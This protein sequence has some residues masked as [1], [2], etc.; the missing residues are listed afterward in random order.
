MKRGTTVLVLV[1][2]L[3]GCMHTRRIEGL[4]GA[5]P[6]AG[7]Q[8]GQAQLDAINAVA[9]GRRGRIE[10]MD[11]HVLA[12][13]Q[14]HAERAWVSWSD[15]GHEAQTLPWSRVARITFRRPVRGALR[16][17]GVGFAAGMATTLGLAASVDKNTPYEDIPPAAGAV[18]IGLLATAATS[19][20]GTVVGG[21]TDR[22]VFVIQQPVR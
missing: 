22:Q 16:G 14:I 10:T 18:I 17:L 21:A 3:S 8:L 13:R 9:L 4:R 2:M 6:D 15:P 1:L 12:A 5:D 19:A 11:G 20:V 7:L